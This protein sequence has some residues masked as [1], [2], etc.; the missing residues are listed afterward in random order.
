MSLLFDLD[1]K[2]SEARNHIT[3][4]KSTKNTLCI[5]KDPEL[6]YKDEQDMVP[7]LLVRLGPQHPK[8]LLIK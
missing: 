4:I 6:E 5:M 1:S 2:L 3:S 7:D 8:L